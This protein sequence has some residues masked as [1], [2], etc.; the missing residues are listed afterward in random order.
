MFKQC[1]LTFVGVLLLTLQLETLQLAQLPAREIQPP[2]G[3]LPSKFQCDSGFQ[4]G[5]PSR[6]LV[7]HVVITHSAVARLK[8]RFLHTFK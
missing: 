6:S 8:I 3:K 2:A 7:S 5:M 4:A 1:S